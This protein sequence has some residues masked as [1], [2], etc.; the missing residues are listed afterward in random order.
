MKK[1]K[2]KKKL[3]NVIPLSLIGIFECYMYSLSIGVLTRH[4]LTLFDDAIWLQ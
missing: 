2:E 3:H 4:S 1:R